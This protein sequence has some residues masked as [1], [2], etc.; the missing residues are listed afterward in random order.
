MVSS[1][2]RQL[3]L[4]IAL[5]VFIGI[6]TPRAP[7]AQQP[8]GPFIP[9][10]VKGS[11]PPHKAAASGHRPVTDDTPVR[12]VP[13]P[14]IIPSRQDITPAGIQ[15]VFESRVF[16]VTFG[17]TS[18]EIYALTAPRRAL[19]I[20]KMDWQANKVLERVSVQGTPGKQGIA[21]DLVTNQPL[22]AAASTEKIEGKV[23]GSVRLLA[24][25]NGTRRS[26]GTRLGPP[27]PGP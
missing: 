16:G 6:S 21:F 5:V 14:G 19:E 20:F 9:P 15:A 12:S 24:V 18:A 8:T 11:T 10:D 26:S 4:L 3:F 7:T 23:R 22:I 25:S 27:T 1:S 2:R 17:A 13:D